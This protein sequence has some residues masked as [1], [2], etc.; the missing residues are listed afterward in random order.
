[1]LPAI[2]W[3]DGKRF[4]FSVFDDTDLATMDNV[5][6]VYALLDD[7]GFKTTKSV[8]PMRGS[9]VPYLGGSTSDD[10]GYRQWTIDL[11]GRGFEIGSHGA[12]FHTSTRSEVI[13]ALD[14]FKAAYGHD[15]YAFANHASCGESIYWGVD[16]VSGFHRLAYQ[17]MT[18]FKSRSRFRGHVVGDEHFWGDVCRERI[19]YVRNFT[20]D[21]VNTLRACPVMPYHD[22]ERPY[23]AMWFAS[24][25][26]KDVRSYCA[27]LTDAN[28]D[29][30][31]SEGGACIMY[32]HFASGFYTDGRL[33]PTFRSTMERLARRDGWFVPVTT[34]LDYLRDHGRGKEITR[35]DRR[36]IERRW[37]ISKARVGAS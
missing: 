1:M 25:E 6:E 2:S 32:T 14:K 22:P 26:G 30:L 31:E 12:T 7:L 17:A 37:L 27:R 28:Q 35:G 9:R 16:R 20:F 29:R 3:P 11:Q 34:L 24:S 8:W 33:D 36:T 4:A 13:E 10:P 15:P 19:R 18:G 21:D 5:P 23:V